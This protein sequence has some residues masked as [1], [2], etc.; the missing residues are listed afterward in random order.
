M[1]STSC[2]TGFAAALDVH[3]VEVSPALRRM[4]WGK[5]QCAGECPEP[6]EDASVGDIRVGSL[7]APEAAEDKGEGGEEGEKEGVKKRATMS[8]VSHLN[9]CTV[10]WHRSLSEVPPGPILLVAHELY[11]ALPVH[12]VQI[13]VSWYL[14]Y[15]PR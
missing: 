10:T 3:L 6:L 5:L 7:H 13:H 2:F 12:Q 4:Q 14:T 9:G 15:T 1:Q 8:G 11:D